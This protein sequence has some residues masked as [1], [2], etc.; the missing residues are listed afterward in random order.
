[1]HC[2]TLLS[3]CSWSMQGHSFSQDFRVL[4][5]QS[6]DMVLGMDWLEHFSPMKVHWGN[7]WM[8]IPYQES[9]VLLQ[10]LTSSVPDDLVVQILSV[11][12]KEEKPDS[13]L[14][15]EIQELLVEFAIVFSTPTEL[16]PSRECDH[17]IPLVAGARPVNV[18]P[19]RYPPALKDEIER[20][21]TEMLQQ[22]II[23][24]SVYPFSSPVLLVKKKDGSW[25]LCV[26]YRYLNALTIR[27]QFP[28][29]VFDQ[30]MDELYGASWFSILDLWAGYH[31]IKLKTGEEYKTAFQTHNGHFEFKVMVFGLCG[32][33][34][35]FQGAMNK[36]LAPLRKCVIVFF[37]DIL[38]YSGSFQ[39]HIIHLRQVL[40]LLAAGKW[41]VKLSK[42]NFAQRQI[43]YMGHVISDKG[44]ATDATK[45]EAVLNWPTPSNVKEL[46]SFLGLA[47]YYR[48]FVKNFDVTAKP[49]TDLL[50]KHALF[51]WTQNQQIAFATLQQA[52]VTAPVLALLDFTK[53]FC[54]ETDAYHN[55]VGA[56]LLHDGH[57]LAFISRPLGPKSQ[58]LSTYEKEYLAILMAIEQW[59]PYLLHQEFVIFTDQKSL[60]HLSEQRLNTAWQQK[61]FTKLLGL[62]YKIIYKQGSDNRVADTLSRRAHATYLCMAISTSVPQWC[63]EIITGY[64]SD[65]ATLQLLSMLAVTPSSVPNFTLEGGLIRFKNRIWLG[66]ILL[67]IRKC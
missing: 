8:P 48:R 33:P 31:Q 39:D 43:S 13:T 9:S 61:V 29:P 23:Q 27:G 10:G 1:M 67:S 12:S 21:V 59:R 55:G 14:P 26:D 25:R 3:D 34:A 37:D 19:Y 16:P 2:S 45:V 4:S 63:E 54:I 30:L 20:Q 18:R 51:V 35:T 65:P 24:P 53:P 62:Q 44:V 49:L 7:K 41:H 47:G 50:K 40:S 42:C 28:I 22:G 5:L 57:P 15:S 52:L 6:Y 58:G 38:V 56:I 66:L 32:G 11:Q 60:I 17:T 64:S 46:R 36:V